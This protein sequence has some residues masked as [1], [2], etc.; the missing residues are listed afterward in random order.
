MGA[1]REGG[2]LLRLSIAIYEA[3]QTGKVPNA[4]GVDDESD[5]A[6][7]SIFFSKGADILS[8]ASGLKDKVGQTEISTAM[9]GP[10]TLVRDYVAPIWP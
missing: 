10:A 5:V 4:V 7:R 3:I 1:Y 6:L 9:K 2:F 8:D